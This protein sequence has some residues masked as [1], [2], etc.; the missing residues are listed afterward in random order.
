MGHVTHVT[1]TSD[2]AYFKGV[3]SSLWIRDLM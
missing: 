2:H 3:M 1:L